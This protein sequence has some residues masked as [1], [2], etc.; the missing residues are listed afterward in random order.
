MDKFRKSPELCL[1]Y[2]L[3]PEVPEL[4]NYII[5]SLGIYGSTPPC[6]M[7]DWDL[8]IVRHNV[9]FTIMFLR[10]NAYYGQKTNIVRLFDKRLSEIP[11]FSD[12]DGNYLR[13]FTRFSEKYVTS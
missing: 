10:E 9:E 3:H 1:K 6:R 11:L 13:R 7:H 4:Q 2:S 12:A 8:G 5:S